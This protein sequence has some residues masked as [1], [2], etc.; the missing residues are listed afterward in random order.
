VTT[1]ADVPEQH[2]AKRLLAAALADGPA[3]AYL[4]HG[5]AGVGKR[6][7][8]RAFA[9]ELLGDARRVDAGTHPD[10]RVIEALGE[11]IRIDEIRA[12]HHDLHMRPFEADR[13]IYLL[14]DAHRMNDEAAASLL[15]D[16]EEP[17]AYATLVL[18]ADELGPLPETIRSR[19]QLV[20]FRRLSRGAVE[21]WIAARAPELPSA[22]VGLLA[23][24][25]GGRLDRAARLLDPDARGRRTA[26]LDAAR[27]VYREETFDPAFAA[28]VVL[29]SAGAAGAAARARE[30]RL[31]EGLELP[32]READQRARRAEFGAE[33]TELLA[34]LDDLA[35]WYRDL[36][37][38]G[39]GAESAAVHA[40]RLEEL[41]ADAAEGAT[42]GAEH[43]AEVV[44]QAW[45]EVE[46]F[47]LNA[48]LLLEA[49]F[50]RV[51]RAFSRPVPAGR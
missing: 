11:M 18:V 5:P 17:P 27:S 14:L 29:Q 42:E 34:S 28:A 19:C 50:V 45:R 41:R 33:R 23:R 12:L 20:P 32:S 47:N 3:H 13:R 7:A 26:L 44:R 9:G 8:A 36:V 30:Q 46:E 16:L 10:L 6:V 31:V 25:S 21:A 49:M 39:A 40:D 48:S 24:V 35:A 15:K 22:D 38:V 2:E 1:L 37:V 4:F 51:E 43:A